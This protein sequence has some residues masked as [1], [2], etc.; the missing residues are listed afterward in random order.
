MFRPLWSVVS[1]R[2]TLAL[3]CS[4]ISGSICRAAVTQLGGQEMAARYWHLA[5]CLALGGCLFGGSDPPPQAMPTPAQAEMPAIPTQLPV[6]GWERVSQEA[7]VLA[8]AVTRVV[9]SCPSGKKVFGGGGSG[10]VPLRSS[11]PS[12]DT[13]WQA[14][15]VNESDLDLTVTAWAICAEAGE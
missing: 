6:S 12:S 5:P 1:S 3:P 8:G 4:S 7:R 15:F 11:S 14:V 10:P 9:A 2:L 13:E